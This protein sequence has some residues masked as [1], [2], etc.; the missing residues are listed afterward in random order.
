M[1]KIR[2]LRLTDIDH[3]GEIVRQEG[4]KFFLCSGKSE[5]RIGMGPYFYPDA[6][7]FECYEEID[8]EEARRI[9]GELS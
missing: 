5:T 4:H 8:E 1:E 9:I 2:Y 3:R 6:P 7:E